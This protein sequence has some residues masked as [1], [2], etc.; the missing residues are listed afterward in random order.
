MKFP[1]IILVACLFASVSLAGCIDINLAKDWLIHEQQGPVAYE[2][3]EVSLNH[4][5]TFN[6]NNTDVSLLEHFSQELKV[7]VPYGSTLMQI[8]F[9]ASISYVPTIGD[10]DFGIY[11]EDRYMAL[12]IFTP[13]GVLWNN[14]NY[15]Q[16]NSITW[17]INSPGNGT[18]TFSLEGSGTG[19]DFA[20]RHDY[21]SLTVRVNQ[22][23]V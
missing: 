4:T 15:N 6:A 23:T 17:P 16:S 5:F 22:P 14:V 13:N 3:N 12:D 19:S 8:D 1:T 11:L 10:L 20:G 18:W 7:D 21:M 2:M 9:D